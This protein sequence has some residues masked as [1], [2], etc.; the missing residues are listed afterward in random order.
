MATAGSRD[1]EPR[2]LIAGLGNWLLQDDGI[3]IHAVRALE[4]D[5][6][7]LMRPNTIAVEVGASALDAVH[8]FEWADVIVAIDAM[9]CG[10]PPGSVYLARAADIHTCDL[11]GGLHEVG[12]IAALQML[13]YKHTGVWMFGVE[14]ELI[15]YGTELTPLVR[16]ALP[17]LLRRVKGWLRADIP[18]AKSV[19]RT[20]PAA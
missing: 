1:T 11:A 19:P 13:N 5:P 18:W 15:D 8:L 9:R 10:G 4:N 20:I 2:V 14:P 3:G 6:E 7:I 12:L 16:A 17:G